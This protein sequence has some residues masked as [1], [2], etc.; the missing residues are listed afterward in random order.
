MLLQ[1]GSAQTGD[2]KSWAKDVITHRLSMKP[3]TEFDKWN[4][5][6][7]T[8][9][10]TIC[11]FIA[12]IEIPK[13]IKKLPN[14]KSG[15][16]SL[17]DNEEAFCKALATKG[18]TPKCFYL[19]ATTPP[20][21]PHADG[22]PSNYVYMKKQVPEG[23]RV[24]AGGE[25]NLVAD[26]YSTKQYFAGDAKVVWRAQ[27]KITSINTAKGPTQLNIGTI[28]F[29]VEGMPGKENIPSEMAV[30]TNSP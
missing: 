17:P 6:Q 11:A 1:N 3:K 10:A 21:Q 14:L 7:W 28:W 4:A 20:F 12:K 26:D 13:E 5:D 15:S 8:N 23:T 16:F 25:C 22:L 19:R 9:A 2:I 24:T 29:D 18:P 30:I 27:P